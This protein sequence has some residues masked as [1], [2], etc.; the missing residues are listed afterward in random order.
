TAATTARAS[1]V[2]APSKP[3]R[4]AGATLLL[5]GD[6]MVD[7]TPYTTLS[8][9]PAFTIRGAG[10][11]LIPLP[12]PGGGRL[13]GPAHAYFFGRQPTGNPSRTRALPVIRPSRV[14]G[15]GGAAAEPVPADLIGWL[16]SRSDLALGKPSEVRIGDVTGTAVEGTVRSGAATNSVGA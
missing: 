10:G 15:G 11:W 1:R 7:G 6:T 9:E 3:P 4:P 2:L 16:R 12:A 14:I 13:E 8:F 5:M